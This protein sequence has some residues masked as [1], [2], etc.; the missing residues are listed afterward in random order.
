MLIKSPVELLVGTVRLF[1]LP[2]HEPIMLIRAGGRLGQDLFDPPNVKGWPGGTRW[3]TSA[4]LLDRWQVLQRSIRGHEMGGMHEAAMGTSATTGM[5]KAHAVHGA[6]W[7]VTE[8]DE[9]I[10]QTLLPIEPVHP[11]ANGEERWHVV[12]RLVM[13]PVYQLK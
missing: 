3:I 11:L 4:T 8:P 7:L 2:V 6:E 13:D 1:G 12:R 9:V 10:K 5:P